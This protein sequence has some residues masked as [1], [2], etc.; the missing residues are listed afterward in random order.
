[1]ICG[2]IRERNNNG[3][4]LCSKLCLLDWSCGLY[5]LLRDVC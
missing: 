3:I 4:V 5:A 2:E 1:M